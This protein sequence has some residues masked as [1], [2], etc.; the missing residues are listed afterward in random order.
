[1]AE[2]GELIALYRRNHESA[3][4]EG[5][6]VD[7]IYRHYGVAS[8]AGRLCDR[9]TPAVGYKLE[10]WIRVLG[11]RVPELPRGEL[12]DRAPPDASP[13]ALE[14][15]RHGSGKQL[16]RREPLSVEAFETALRFAEERVAIVA[17]VVALMPSLRRLDPLRK[18]LHTWQRLR[19]I[20][21]QDASQL[22]IAVS[23]VEIVDE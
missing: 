22:G 7:A 16:Y 14:M 1:M 20:V 8:P 21:R 18:Q 19:E 9:Y 4:A 15:R 6:F 10:D 11:G 12:P 2:L 23:E 3:W 13:L 17:R 5:Y